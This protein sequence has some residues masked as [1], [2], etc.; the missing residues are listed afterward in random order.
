MVAAVSGSAGWTAAA[1]D[2]G[3]GDAD[4]DQVLALQL[5]FPHEPGQGPQVAPLGDDADPPLAP[6]L[7]LGLGQ[8]EG[9]IVDAGR[10]EDEL[11]GLVRR[12]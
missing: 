6:H 2:P 9:E 4:D 10:G 8:V 7:L 11:V 3:A 1:V 5:R 12:R